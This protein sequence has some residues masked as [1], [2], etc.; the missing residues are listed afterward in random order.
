MRIG[1]MPHVEHE[2]VF[3]KIENIVQRDDHVHRAEI[4]GKMPSVFVGDR[5]DPLADLAGENI[6]L[7]HP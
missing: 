6:Q 5:N 7:F 2:F 3:R 1:L 4:G